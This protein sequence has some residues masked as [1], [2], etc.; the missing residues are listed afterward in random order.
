VGGVVE[1][2][3]VCLWQIGGVLGL[4]RTDNLTA[5]VRDLDRAGMHEFTQKYRALLAHYGMQPSANTAGCAN[6][7]GDVE[8]SHFRFKQAV[9]QALRVRGT[10]EFETR[11][12]YEHFFGELVRQRN[13]ARL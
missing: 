4:H 2:L 1:A 13:L 12:V 8:Q 10:R 5:A 9:D 11:S 3:E 6:Q 7:N